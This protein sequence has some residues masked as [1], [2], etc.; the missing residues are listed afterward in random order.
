MTKP[1]A[2]PSRS[3]RETA[4]P[5]RA[6]PPEDCPVKDRCRRARA[7]L[8]LDC[9]AERRPKPAAETPEQAEADQSMT[10]FSS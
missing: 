10:A 4:R 5:T 8:C 1:P 3:R 6:D 2:R 7:A 9:G